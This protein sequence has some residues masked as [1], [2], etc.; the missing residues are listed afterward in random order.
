[1]EKKKK[2]KVIDLGVI[3]RKWEYHPDYRLDGLLK[4]CKYIKWENVTEWEN[5]A[6]KE[7]KTN[8]HIRKT[9]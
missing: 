3:D 8:E 9:I 7:E 1:V 5:V 2:N 4:A 6:E